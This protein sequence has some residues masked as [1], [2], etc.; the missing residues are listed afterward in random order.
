[1]RRDASKKGIVGFLTDSRGL[2][3]AQHGY[4]LNMFVLGVLEE[5]GAIYDDFGDVVKQLKAWDSN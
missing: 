2:N 1:M 5:C 3:K 4:G